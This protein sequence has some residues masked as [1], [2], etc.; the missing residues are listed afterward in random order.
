MGSLGLGAAAL[1]VMFGFFLPSH[2]YAGLGD[3]VLDSIVSD[4]ARDSAALL[5]I[6]SILIAGT[7]MVVLRS[8]GVVIVSVVLLV[9]GVINLVR[10]APYY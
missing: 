4:D 1:L 10:L 8:R 9:L 7:T 2:D 3:P 6:A 5:A